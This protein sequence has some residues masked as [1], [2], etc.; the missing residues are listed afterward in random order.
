MLRTIP[1][2]RRLAL[3]L[4][5]LAIASCGFSAVAQESPADRFRGHRGSG[6]Y[7]EC[8]VSMP[9]KDQ[10][11]V[12]LDLPGIGNGS[13]V[14]WQTTPNSPRAYLLSSSPTDATRHAIA[15]DLANNTVLWNKSYTST[16]HRLHQFTTYASSTP[17]VD[18]NG[19]YIAWGEPE[20]V[21][22]KHLGHDGQ[23]IWSRDF[24]RYVSQHGFATS[25]ML[26]D[27]KLIL[28]DSQDAEE[29]EAGVEPGEDRMLALDAKTGQTLWERKLPTKRVCYGLPNVRVLPDGSK[30]RSEH[31]RDQVES[32]LLQTTDLFVDLAGRAASDRNP[33]LRG[34]EGQ[35]A[36]G[37]RY[38]HP[39]GAIPDPTRSALCPHTGG[40]RGFAI[41]LVRCWDRLVR[42][43]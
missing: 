37:L 5:A 11:V 17:A 34:W 16:K 20:H 23:E 8:K 19:I 12:K 31:R 10:D 28:L 32:R 30:D 14:V 40:P 18:S 7:P 1:R 13:P 26:L 22:V 21:Y 27:G 41:P 2:V 33:R 4:P 25:P 38:G 29:L 42:Q 35:H 36:R 43:A 9:W 6:V 15:V 24:G 39:A 3:C